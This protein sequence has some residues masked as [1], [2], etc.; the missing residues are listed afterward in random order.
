MQS[1]VVKV[2]LF[3]QRGVCVDV[4]TDSRSSTQEAKYI[5]L[6]GALRDLVLNCFVSQVGWKCAALESITHYSVRFQTECQTNKNVDFRDF[7]TLRV[8]CKVKG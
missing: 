4:G 2:V 3:E 8:R 7:E 6:H 5:F 1:D